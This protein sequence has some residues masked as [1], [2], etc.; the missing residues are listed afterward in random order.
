MRSGECAAGKAALLA[1][2]GAAGVKRANSDTH[3]IWTEEA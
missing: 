3:G 1:G 2:N